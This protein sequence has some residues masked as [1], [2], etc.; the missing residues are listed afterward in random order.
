MEWN[1]NNKK[2]EETHTVLTQGKIDIDIDN[3]DDGVTVTDSWQ[4]GF[5]G[6]DWLM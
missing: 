5:D 6:F 2:P 4:N 3:G 1:H